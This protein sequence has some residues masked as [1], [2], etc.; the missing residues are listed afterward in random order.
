[1]KTKVL[2]PFNLTLFLAVIERRPV[3]LEKFLI[4]HCASKI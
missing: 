1:M 3:G 2:R 4:V